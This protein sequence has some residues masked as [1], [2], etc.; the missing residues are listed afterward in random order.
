MVV[1][2]V[3][4]SFLLWLLLPVAAASGWFA[5]AK[6][7]RGASRRR[8]RA[9][10]T[11]EYFKGI[12]YVLNEQPDK[13]IEVFIKV[14]EV[15]TETVE[16]HLAL[17]NLYRRRGEVDRA[18]RIH[19]NLVAR[20]TTSNEQRY[21]ALLELAQDYLSAGLLDRAENLFREL[22]EVGHHTVQALR[23]LIDIYEQE[24]DWEQAAAAAGQLGD[25][26]GS[27]LGNVIA[28]YQCEQAEQARENGNISEALG[29][30]TA[31]RESYPGCVRASIVEGDIHAERG[32]HALALDAYARVEEQDVEYVPEVVERI[33]CCME[34]LDDAS[35]AYAFLV[36]MHEGHG[37]MTAMLALAER[38]R[39]RQGTGQAVDFVIGELAKRP[40]LRGFEWLLELHD[41]STGVNGSDGLAARHW[42]ILQKLTA[43]LLKER[44]VYKCEHCG[45]PAKLLHWRCPGCKHWSSVR[46]IRG[47][48]GE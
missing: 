20:S 16:T 6:A 38:L 24:K 11:S 28:Q 47:I 34:A 32:D 36:K 18:I 39:Q 12:N 21:E 7:S 22:V 40:T 45:F 46:P 30:L 9:E 23:Q 29:L 4:V 48:E 3:D 33:L 10:L 31:A 25:A 8:A 1:G 44:P 5:A 43:S 19:Q 37:G 35:G 27:H 2:E 41:E 17:G 26:T 42:S 14:L 15:D 13:A